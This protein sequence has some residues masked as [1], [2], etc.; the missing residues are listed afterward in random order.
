MLTRLKRTTYRLD[1]SDRAAG[2]SAYTFGRPVRL[3]TAI[4]IRFSDWPLKLS[5]IVGFAFSMLSAAI[6]NL[7][8]VA[9]VFGVFAVPGWTSTILSVWFLSGLIM[10]TLG[11]LGFYP[12]RNFAAVKAQ[13]QIIFEQTTRKAGDLP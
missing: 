10:A 12:G 5:V 6:S 7:P 8:F 1:R 3:A 9:W 4:I 11:I 13:L 2:K